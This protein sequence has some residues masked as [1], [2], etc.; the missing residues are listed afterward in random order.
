MKQ[1]FSNWNILRI[2]RIALGVF[3]IG[4]GINSGQWGFIF[5]GALFT[6]M[7]LLNIGCCANNSCSTPVNDTPSSHQ[8]DVIF[9]EIK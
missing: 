1:L 8:E 6:I 7:P 4:E 3:I 5:I 2:A 9:E